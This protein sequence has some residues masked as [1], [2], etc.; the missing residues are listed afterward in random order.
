[1][2]TTA[3][4]SMAVRSAGTKPTLRESAQGAAV[5]E[6]QGKLHDAGF[7]PGAI[8]GSFGPNTERAVMA[9]QRACGLAIDGVVGPQTWKALD[10]RLA[11]GGR[12]VLRRGATGEA[13]REL[14][15]RLNVLGFDC[16]AADGDFGA[17]TEASV[18]GFQQQ[19]GLVVDGI[20]G[21]RTWSALGSNIETS[22][23]GGAGVSLEQL[24]AIMTNLSAARGRECLPH[25]NAAMTE[26][27]IDRRLRRAAFIA[28]LAHE[29]SELR[30]FEELADGSAY[31]GR[32]DLGNTQ[33]GDGRRYK[34]RGPIQLTG[35]SNYRAAGQAL[36]LDLEGQPELA[37]HVD[38]GFRVA[39]WF[40]TRHNL[41]VLADAGQFTEITRKINGG[42]N[43]Q[44]S[45]EQYYQ[46]ALR[47]VT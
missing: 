40:W 22:P 44:R 38:L 11:G 18:R 15:Q 2:T 32:R 30:Y 24:R 47:I 26:A 28:Q 41:N 27:S 45:R 14:Q 21:P 3:S 37:A 25:L 4:I 33:P 19:R 42:L 43:G 16:G 17:R 10:D 5:T 8:D 7:D 29:S 46:R 20:V 35:R 9:F 31:E 39:G 13:V 36:H 6:L 23:A 34:G 12:P 1:M